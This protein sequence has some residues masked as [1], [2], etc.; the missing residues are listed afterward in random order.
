MVLA[1][2]LLCKQVVLFSEILKA[3]TDKI[4]STVKQCSIE[5]KYRC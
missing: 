1:T 2:R 5:R 4:K 3:N